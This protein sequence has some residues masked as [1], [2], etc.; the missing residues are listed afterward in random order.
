MHV[1]EIVT[2]QQNY[3]ISDD[4]KFEN[5]DLRNAIGGLGKKPDYSERVQVDAS[6]S[7]IEF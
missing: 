3:R 7:G 1:V 5:R 6:A 4:T 2:D